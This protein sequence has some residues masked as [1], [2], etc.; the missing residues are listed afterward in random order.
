MLKIKPYEGVETVR[1]L[2]ETG[3]SMEIFAVLSTVIFQH[4]SRIN[5]LS[6]V[7]PSLA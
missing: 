3:P 5:T 7:E 4:D 2:I 6:R 1:R